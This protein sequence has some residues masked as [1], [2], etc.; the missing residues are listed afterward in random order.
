MPIP[1]SEGSME[2][3]EG[4]VVWEMERQE[5]EVPATQESVLRGRTLLYVGA[6]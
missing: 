1:K 2:R 5:Q 4:G 3:V 6:A